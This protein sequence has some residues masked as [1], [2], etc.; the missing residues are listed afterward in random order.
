MQIALKN[1]ND[2]SVETNC[3][4]SI[5]SFQEILQLKYDL[6]TNYFSKIKNILFRNYLRNITN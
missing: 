3:L 6:E 1:G 2:L 5:E 4:P